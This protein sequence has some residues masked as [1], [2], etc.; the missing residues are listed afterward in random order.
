M[1]NT[2]YAKIVSI[3]K[4]SPLRIHTPEKAPFFDANAPWM[5][6][7]LDAENEIK[8]EF[9][10]KLYGTY[11]GEI[12]FLGAKEKEK[13]GYRN[14]VA[15]AF[16][17]TKKGVRFALY[18]RGD[19]KAHKVEQKENPLAH[20]LIEKV[21]K[22]F[23]HFFHQKNIQSK[24]LKYLI[25]RYSFLTNKIVAYLLLPET[26]RKKLPFKKSDLEK[27]F[28][29]HENI[30]GIQVAHS[31]AGIRSAFSEKT[32]YN[33]GD[34]EVEEK[35]LQKTYLYAPSLF[36]QINPLGF[37]NIL[38]DLREE[39]KKIPER[40]E[41]PL[42]DLF[43]GVGLIGIELADLVKKVEGVEL[44][45]L[46]KSYALKNAERNGI[47]NFSF[48]EANVDDALELI[49]KEQILVLDPPRRGLSSKTIE[50][51]QRTK[52][53]Y[54]FY[55]SCNPQTQHRDIEKIKDLYE[56]RFIKVYNIFPRTQH[57]ESF[58]VLERK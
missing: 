10:T 45:S 33:I 6:L 47:E 41:L 7:S 20:P 25:L 37:Q 28:G 55:V 21:G 27:F 40:K 13:L 9:I 15:Y 50:R 16:L 54:I 31:E 30:Q 49:E 58:V 24:D 19:G 11:K 34:I 39:M 46:S 23:L 53:K 4:T 8:R 36:F 52:P 51:I 56:I 44:S 2:H 14:K 18:T 5:H 1:G 38:G 12:Q 32:F 35:M 26:N 29:A 48:Q 3:L 57:I 22:Q 42:L 43:A 17:D